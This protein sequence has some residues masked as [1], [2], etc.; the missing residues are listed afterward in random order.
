[1]N[2]SE[3]WYTSS[4]WH[5][6]DTGKVSWTSE[7]WFQRYEK[8]LNRQ[9]TT[10]YV[11][12]L[13]YSHRRNLFVG[14]KKTNKVWALRLGFEPWDQD[15]SRREGV[16]WRRRRSRRNFPL[17]EIIGYWP[18]RGQLKGQKLNGQKL[19]GKRLKKAWI[20]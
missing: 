12:L 14:D 8:V 18:L 6:S 20:K 3:N 10:D 19:K 7:A 13:L 2:F 9:T 16:H 5:K 11:S 15:I 4:H 1:M 17:Y